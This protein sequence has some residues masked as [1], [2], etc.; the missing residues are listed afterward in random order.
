MI[1]RFGVGQICHFL[2]RQ[3]PLQKERKRVFGTK[4]PDWSKFH[5]NKPI[6]FF[7]VF[8]LHPCGASHLTIFCFFPL[9]PLKPRF[10]LLSS[11]HHSKE[12][13]HSLE[14]WSKETLATPQV[15]CSFLLNLNIGWREKNPSLVHMSSRRNRL[16]QRVALLGIALFLV[17]TLIYPH[18][19]VLNNVREGKKKKKP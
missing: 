16:L 11:S 10:L 7:L 3:V 17:Q 6:F 12:R 14:K 8:L 13:R 9:P 19:P 15:T 5:S 1:N 18:F 2:I 4:M